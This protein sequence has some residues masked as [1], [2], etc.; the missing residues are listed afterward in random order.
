VF[1]VISDAFRFEAAE[2][3]VCRSMARAV[4]R[5]L[6]RHAGGAAELYRAGHGA[7]LPH[8][9]L[10]YKL[11]AN[12]DVMADD[13]AGVHARATQRTT[14][15][16]IQGVAIKADDL[17]ALGKD[18]GREFVRDQKVI[19]VYHDKIDM[20]GD[21]QARNQDLRRRGAALLELTQLARLHRQQPQ[22]F[23]GADHGR[24]WLSVS[25]IA[26]GRGRQIHL[27]RQA[28]WAR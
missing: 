12:L 27:G 13:A 16:N 5:P 21:K 3:L 18:K 23:A 1:V 15:P 20:L 17:L 10:A 11:N 14:A 8:Q 4:S 24:P 26:A 9:S 19:Y 22:R 7:L 6:C 25:G 2:E 28:R